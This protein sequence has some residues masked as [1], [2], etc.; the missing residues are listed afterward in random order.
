MDG[1]Y[2]Q[3]LR[4]DNIANNLSNINTN[5]FKKSEISFEE[6]L[7]TVIISEIDLSPG[8]VVHTGNQLDIAVNGKGFFKVNTSNGVRYTRDG[9]FSINSNGNLVTRNGDQVLGENGPITIT[10]SEI[11][12]GR[13]G[14]I[15]ADGEQ[16]GK[17]S[18]VDFDDVRFLQKEGGSNYAYNGDVGN[19]KIFENP[20]IRQHHLE[21]SNV[22]TTEEMIKMMDSHRTFE[23]IQ[24]AIQN[25]DEVT[26][27]MVNDPDL[28]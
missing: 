19:I 25:M 12:I 14:L 10:G 17:L 21:K 2:V 4:F 15:F 24:K 7:S 28:I 22:D 1:A 9:A 16:A 13:D 27:K 11:S 18:V 23:S 5:G 6:A 26:S 20:D 8:P 3:Q